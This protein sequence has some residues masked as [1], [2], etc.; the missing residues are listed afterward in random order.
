MDWNR[1]EGNWKQV[2]GRVKE[3]WGYLTDHDLDVIN[4]RR[5]Q[6]EGKL[7]ERYGI[8]RASSTSSCRRKAMAMGCC[9]GSAPT[10]TQFNSNVIKGL[11]FAGPFFMSHRVAV[12]SPLFPG[13]TEDMRQLHET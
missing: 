2:K 13:I 12:C 6:L 8:A 5:D 11:A 7:Q 9:F 1:L 4:G 3:N 10:R